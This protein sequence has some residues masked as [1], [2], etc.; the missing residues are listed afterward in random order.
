M[1]FNKEPNSIVIWDTYDLTKDTFVLR[2]CRNGMQFKAGQ[3]LSVGVWGAPERREYSI[4]SSE[5]DDFLEVLVKIVEKGKVSNALRKLKPGDRLNVFGPF[6]FF[7]PPMEDIAQKHHLFVATGTGI[8]PFISMIRTHQGLRY[9][10]LHGIRTE[11]E[12]YGKKEVPKERYITCVSG[13]KAGVFQGRVTEYLKQM[14]IIEDSICY[15]CGNCEM[16]YDAYDILK[17]KGFSANRI[18][19]EVY[20]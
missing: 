17:D 4:Y 3:T 7:V 11:K 8:S 20:F 19:T 2:F 10:L 12:A 1:L 15:L 13:E 16:I 9:D 18:F 6:G 5:N 14:D